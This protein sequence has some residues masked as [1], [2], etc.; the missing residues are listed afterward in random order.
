MSQT[1]N[2]YESPQEIGASEGPPL[3][4]RERWASGFSLLIALAVLFGFSAPA[5]PNLTL[6]L[7]VLAAVLLAGAFLCLGISVAYAILERRT[8]S[9]PLIRLNGDKEG[10][11]K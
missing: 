8:A 11:E 2:P 3:S 9:T 5:I 4:A 1:P 7:A 10:L 6:P